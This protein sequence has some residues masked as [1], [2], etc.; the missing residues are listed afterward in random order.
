MCAG[1]YTLLCVGWESDVV[2]LMDFYSL[3]WTLVTVLVVCLLF[4]A[5]LL[6]L[7]LATSDLS[8]LSHIRQFSPVRKGRADFHNSVPLCLFPLYFGLPS[9]L[10]PFS[11]PMV[12]ACVHP[13]ILSHL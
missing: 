10:K 9:I 12:G 7:P 5:C 1:V 13:D 8:Y 2:V 3:S 4:V 11:H 6:L